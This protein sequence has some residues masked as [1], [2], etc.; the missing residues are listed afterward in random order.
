MVLKHSVKQI[1]ANA[2]DTLDLADQG[3]SDADIPEL[4]ALLRAKSVSFLDLGRN[5]IRH[6]AA[7]LGGLKIPHVNLD[8][9]NVAG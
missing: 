2:S 9:N 4:C 1:I 6:K 3:I 7:A 8:Q 5:N